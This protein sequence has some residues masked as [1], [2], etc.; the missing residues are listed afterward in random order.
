[1][2]LD[3]VLHLGVKELCCLARDPIMLGLIVW[4]FTFAIYAAA[5]AMPETLNKAP[6]AIVDL[7]LIH[8]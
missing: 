2:R 7:S 5:T 1:M 4:A 3:N 6:I 8:I